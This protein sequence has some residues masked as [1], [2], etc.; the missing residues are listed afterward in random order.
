M[1]DF[2]YTARELSGREVT[3]LLTAGSE[4]EAVNSLAVKSLFPTQIALA[5]TEVR[6]QQAVT[7]RVRAR[8]I[9]TVYS[10]L[11][12]LLASGVPLLRSLEILEQQSPPPAVT[13]ALHDLRPQAPEDT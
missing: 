6:Q 11:A 7:K 3:G 4:Q 12:D 13:A 10:Q 8:H 2:Q 9:A 5:E 1:P